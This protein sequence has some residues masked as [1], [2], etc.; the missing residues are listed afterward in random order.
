MALLSRC[1]Y[2]RRPPPG[3]R[4][5]HEATVDACRLS[6][7]TL[8]H[9]SLPDGRGIAPPA[10]PL[11]PGQRLSRGERVTVRLTRTGLVFRPRHLDNLAALALCRLPANGASPAGRQR[12]RRIRNACSTL[13]GRNRSC[14][15]GACRH[16]APGP[17]RRHQGVAKSSTLRRKIAEFQQQA[18]EL[19]REA[20]L[21]DV[22]SRSPILRS[23]I[24][25]I[26]KF[27]IKGHERR[28]SMP[29]AGAQGLR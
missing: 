6:A 14:R 18:D 7:T 19:V 21:D 28:P 26:R 10:C 2:A 4:F 24:S 27:D 17:A 11:P 29:M 9:L 12:R 3:R 23:T 25:D 8:V 5:R 13:P 20:K 16:R 1:W 15:G 22:R